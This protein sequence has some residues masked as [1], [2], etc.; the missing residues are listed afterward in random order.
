MQGAEAPAPETRH[1]SQGY[2]A[3]CNAAGGILM[4]DQG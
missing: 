3:E 4:V 2:G 1:T